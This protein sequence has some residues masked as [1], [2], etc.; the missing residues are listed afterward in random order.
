M[1]DP[2]KVPVVVVGSGSVGGSLEHFQNLGKKAT[3]LGAAEAA[4]GRLTHQSFIDI[5][6]ESF[7][8]LLFIKARFYLH[9]SSS[10]IKFKN[11]RLEKFRFWEYVPGHRHSLLS[12]NIIVSGTRLLVPSTTILAAPQSS[13]GAP[14]L[15]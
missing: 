2:R 15:P 8:S 13:L 9:S 1:E 5:N 6:Y 4:R 12:R 11:V 14:P 3:P 10:D 7:Q